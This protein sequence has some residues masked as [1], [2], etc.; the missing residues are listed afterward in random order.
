M[1]LLK[2]PGV[3]LLLAIIVVGGW[4]CLCR[5]AYVSVGYCVEAR[6]A[7]LP[8]D[9]RPLCDWLKAQPGVIPHP[10]SVCREG[11]TAGW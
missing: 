10:V 3:L 9:D 7:S 8:A 6:F 4:Q 2:L 1:R 11:P 5:N